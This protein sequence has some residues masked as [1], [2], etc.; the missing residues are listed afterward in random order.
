MSA[1]P[2]FSG[3]TSCHERYY[4]PV[5]VFDYSPR[6]DYDRGLRHIR[7]LIDR[8]LITA[9]AQMRTGCISSPPWRNLRAAK[10]W[11]VVVPCDAPKIKVEFAVTEIMESREGVESVAVLQKVG[12]YVSE[13][14]RFRQSPN[15]LAMVGGP[16][17]RAQTTGS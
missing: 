17:S 1:R 4:S 12:L 14:T 15:K 5:K 6:E 16:V 3:T 10:E 11:I 7:A 9:G 2:S 8:M 13:Y